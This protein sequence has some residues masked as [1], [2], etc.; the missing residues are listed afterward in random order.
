MRLDNFKQFSGLSH[1]GSFNLF[2]FNKIDKL[3]MQSIGILDYFTIAFE[4]E[5]E[6]DDDELKVPEKIET[7][8]T[9]VKQLLIERLDSEK[10][11][12]DEK[13]IDS[14]ILMFDEKTETFNIEYLENENENYIFLVLQ[15]LMEDELEVWNDESD[16][17]EP[18]LDYA[19][20]MVKKYL[21]NFYKKYS[22]ILKFE[23]DHSLN[24]GIEFSPITY[25]KSLDVAIKMLE[26]FFNDFKNQDYWFM[27]NSTS[28]HINIGLDKKVDWNLSKGVLILNDYSESNLP[29]VFKGIEL[30]QET[31]FTKSLY[32]I[33]NQKLKEFNFEKFNKEKIENFINLQLEEIF[34]QLGSKNFGF[35]I[36]QI[37]KFNYVEFRY[38]GGNLTKELVVDKL[39]YFC[40]IV[41]CMTSDWKERDYIKKLYKLSM[42]K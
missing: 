14:L 39:I 3:K 41:Y 5:L 20:E 30:R 31:N 7:L 18:S 26:D 1:V 11:N 25:V 8:L 10:I 42:I 36:Q 21:P 2:E 24:K 28:I 33:I 29:F 19:K 6:C 27:S 16:K 32:K 4:F 15:E 12:Y 22:K 35:N 9:L 23:F 38:V 17:I 40:Y 13:L 34:E 37:K